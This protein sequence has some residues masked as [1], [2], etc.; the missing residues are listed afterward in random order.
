MSRLPLFLLT[1][2]ID[3]HFLD[4]YVN[5]FIQHVLSFFLGGAWVVLSSFTQH[6]YVESFFHVVAYIN[7]KFLLIDK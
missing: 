4:F 7:S 3:L 6:N 5:G 2:Q 1:V